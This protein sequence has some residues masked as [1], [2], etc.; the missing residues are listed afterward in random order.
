MIRRL[1][2]A[3][4]RRIQHLLGLGGVGFGQAKNHQVVLRLRYLA[5]LLLL[6]RALPGLLDIRRRRACVARS[7]R[8][9]CVPFVSM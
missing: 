6:H 3:R 4:R 8:P 7:R 2:Q 5:V 1:Q 9:F